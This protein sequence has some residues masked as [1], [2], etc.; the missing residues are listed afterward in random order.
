MGY[1]YIRTLFDGEVTDYL[2]PNIDP[3]TGIV[4]DS[5]V[6]R[7]RPIEVGKLVDNTLRR[8]TADISPKDPYVTSTLLKVRDGMTIKPIK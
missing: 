6:V 8:V 3:L 7:Y 5:N 4:N 1:C 2:S